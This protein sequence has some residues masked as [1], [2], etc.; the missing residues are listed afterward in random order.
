MVNLNL[1][2][3]V[4]EIRVNHDCDRDFILRLNLK[5]IVFPTYTNYA[6]MF[7]LHF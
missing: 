2:V 7:L 3:E 6:C 1:F 4:Y 5:F